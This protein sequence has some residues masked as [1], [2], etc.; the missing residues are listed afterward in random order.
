[1]K[2][3]NPVYFWPSW[4]LSSF[5]SKERTKIKPTLIKKICVGQT[6]LWDALNIYD[7][8]LDGS[9][10][11]KKLPYANR[12]FRNFLEI[13]YRLDLPR[14]FY[15][16]FNNLLTDLENA[17][18][19]ELTE[20]KLKIENGRISFPKKIPKFSPL[21]DLAKKSLALCVGPLAILYLVNKKNSAAQITGLISFF[22]SALAA[23]Q[24]SDDAKDWFDDLKNGAL[25]YPV[26]LILKK[27]KKNNIKLDTERKPEIIYLLFSQ[28]APD[29]SREIKALCLKARQDAKK[30]NFTKD[31][32]LLLNIIT[33]LEEAVLKAQKFNTLLKEI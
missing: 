25:T 8:I 2:I 15:Q 9:S 5:N 18:K 24:L 23:K 3:I 32:P 1:M 11:A 7:D 14:K 10:D 30:I 16:I 33:P 20:L 22:R 12:Y 13:Y 6:Y 17:N 26:S 4:L 28:T 29:I 31:N 27:A 21:E 19:K